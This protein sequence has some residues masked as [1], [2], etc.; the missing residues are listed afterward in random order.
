MSKTLDRSSQ[1][2][3][4]QHWLALS[5][6]LTL[7]GCIVAYNLVSM[8]QRIISQEHQRLTNQARVI[9]KNIE[10]QL[11]ATSLT[12][13]GIIDDLPELHR[14]Q[15]HAQAN[16][17]LSV[18][19]D[20]MPGVRTLFYTDAKGTILASNRQELIGRNV[21]T[22][23]FFDE[24]RR[25]PDPDTL[26]ISPPFKSVLNR[27]VFDLTKIIP[28]P[29]GSF[30]GIVTAGVDPDYFETILASTLYAPD[31][32]NTINHGDGLRFMTMPYR[33]GQVGKNLAVP[34]SLFTRHKESGK[35]ENIF[36]DTAYAT[37]EYRMVA[38]L[39]LQP[40]E[41]KM[42]KPLVIIISRS[43]DA[44][45]ESWKNEAIFQGLLFL[46]ACIGS[47]IGLFLLHR[48][49]SLFE[50]QAQRAE[51]MVQIRYE[52]LE[53][54]TMHTVDELL[55]YGLDEVCRISDSPI[56]FYHFV[57]PD[58][59][60]LT[61]QAWST[62]TLQEFCRAEGH[63]MHYGVE[64]AGVWAECIQTRAPAIHNDYAGL[65]NKKGLPPGHAPVMRELVVPVIRDER[66]VAVL[67]VG[68]KES[69]YTLKDAEE[70]LY[71]A[72]VT[73]EI[74]DSRRSQ[75]ELK[76]ANELLANHARI[77]Y[78]T[79]IYNRRM[80]DGLMTA[81]I[82]RSYRYNSSLS[83]IM[84]DIDHF[85]QVNDTLGHAAG[86]HVLQ[87]IA[88][89]ISGRIR[90]Y[91]IFSRWGGEEFVIMAPKNDVCKAAELAEILREAIEQFDFG[92]GLKITVSFGVTQYWYGEEPEEFV[93]RA[94]TALYQAKH[95]GRNRVEIAEQP[96]VL[97]KNCVTEELVRLP[98]LEASS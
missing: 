27:Y 52:L 67:G 89:L 88:E 79:G 41:L 69:D 74:I 6:A 72:D 49:Q 45:L 58:Q 24:P 4:R 54:A 57:D 39:T 12:L 56:G 66:I 28:A 21:T 95:K 96:V 53:Y 23:Q 51:A 81:E 32:W 82:A 59:Q 85:K 77:D 13:E 17:R 18:L 16:K 92:N 75:E 78:L 50:K 15:N 65:P 55:Q 31:M 93:A 86:D 97:S 76:Q 1:Y 43:P 10:R 84:M 3:M 9:D 44:V 5:V 90:N 91:D 73:W 30:N 29:D 22:R 64:Q 36:T 80:F 70:V 19:A 61:L 71:L 40:K 98:L 47:S 94:D 35:P 68:N 62:R 87:K 83:L 20:A 26:Y 2:R 46:V 25:H 60:A 38:L 14:P 63:G 8:R 11:T 48:R 33:E 37:G 7:L 34:G 42:D